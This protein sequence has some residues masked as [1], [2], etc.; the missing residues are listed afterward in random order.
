MVSIKHEF[1]G[2]KI[3]LLLATVLVTTLYMTSLCQADE[4]ARIQALDREASAASATANGLCSA[5][6]ATRAQVT[7]LAEQV[8]M[9]HNTFS[10]RL[11][12]SFISS[13]QGDHQRIQPLYA[14]LETR[15]SALSQAYSSIQGTL[16]LLQQAL[17][18]GLQPGQYPE[19]RVLLEHAHTI[20]DVIDDVME[21][22]QPLMSFTPNATYA[23]WMA[24]AYYKQNPQWYQQR[25][26]AH[27]RLQ[28]SLDAAMRQAHG[29]Y[30]NR[31][32]VAMSTA[33]YHQV[34]QEFRTMGNAVS[35]ALGDA[36]QA[37]RSTNEIVSAINNYPNTIRQHRARLTQEAETQLQQIGKLL[38]QAQIECKQTAKN[39]AMQKFGLSAD[40]KPTV[41]SSTSPYAAAVLGKDKVVGTTKNKNSIS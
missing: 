21:E 18:G 36:S 8:H 35:T 16:N 29:I 1:V 6:S 19:G 2:K 17:S 32:H 23:Q 4:W 31:T 14:T 26:Q 38:E 40:N 7:S 41:P 15:I 13:I 34:S 22:N 9:S 33:Q 25:D 12:D 27:V 30:A 5:Q 28:D 24:I 37:M 11:Q 10:Q 39:D 3:G 20:R